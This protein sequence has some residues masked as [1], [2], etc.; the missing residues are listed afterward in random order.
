MKIVYLVI[1][2]L[3]ISTL[4]ASTQIQVSDIEYTLRNDD[5]S[6]KGF[7]SLGEVEYFIERGVEGTKISEVTD[8]GL[9]LLHHLKFRPTDSILNNVASS[10]ENSNSGIIYDDKYLYE[11]YFDYI[12]VIDILA[13]DLV[14]V[15]DLKEQNIVLVNDFVV[16]E[17]F[18]YFT[19]TS[20][21]NESKQIRYDRLQ[22]EFKE[23]TSDIRIGNDLYK[24]S[25]SK[26]QIVHFD[27]SSDISNTVDHG[28]S[29]LN[30]LRKLFIDGLPTLVARDLNSIVTIQDGIVKS[31]NFCSLPESQN[32]ISIFNNTIVTAELH[33]DKVD[34]IFT[35]PTN[36]TSSLQETFSDLSAAT[37]Q[38]FN[39]KEIS[40]G[41]IIFGQTNGW[42]GYGIFYIMNLETGAFT[43]LSL[44]VDILD[45]D[46]VIRYEN[47]LYIIV[48]DDIHYYGYRP[49][50]YSINL[51]D[52]TFSKIG[53]S[54]IID[55]YQI[56]IGESQSDREINVYYSTVDSASLFSLETE[57]SELEKIQ[58]LDYF[59]N[60]GIHFDIYANIWSQDDYFFSTS[61]A[62]FAM[63]DD[64]VTKVLDVGANTHSTSSF[65]EY[66]DK[67]FVLSAIG[68]N[69]YAL[70]IFP[71]FLTVSQKLI[72]ELNYIYYE[73]I[74]TENAIVNLSNGNL[75]GYYD[76]VSENYFAFADLGL[77]SA[78]SVSGNNILTQQSNSDG[79]AWKIHN[80]VTKQTITA[81]ITPATFPEPFP[82]G[83]G[84]F[85]L[86]GWQ[87]S[88]PVNL[89]YIDP[90]G[91]K[92]ILEE[93]FKHQLFRDGNKS[94]GTIKSLAF[95]GDSEM[96]IFSTDGNGHKIKTIPDS[97]IKYYQ[98]GEYYWYESDNR[99]FL[100]IKDGDFYDLY[101]F[102]YNSDPQL[103]LDNKKERL[104]LLME[105]EDKA[106]LAFRDSSQIITFYD[107]FYSNGTFIE[108]QSFQSSKY[109]SYDEDITKLEDSKYLLSLD[110]GIHGLEP[111]IYNSDNGELRLLK[112]IN[113]S[114]TSSQK[115][116]STISPSGEIYFTA[117]TPERDRQLFKLDNQ[118]VP[119]IEQQVPSPTDIVAYPSPSNGIIR[120]LED[121]QLLEIYNIKGQ[122][123]HREKDYKK[124]G[125]INLS[126]L[127]NGVYIIK[128]YPTTDRLK[129]GKLIIQK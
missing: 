89:F 78:K 115:G 40:D 28:F 20:T 36:C 10:Y 47:D 39:F 17:N 86:N 98:G 16:E 80:T 97:G 88:D 9:E 15:I 79:G 18:M 21:N 67:V 85:Y 2:F 58:E 8:N 83:Q 35:D 55:H 70:K 64:L 41:Y 30:S 87:F 102:D 22:E 104:I 14:K 32:I 96:I 59:R 7:I 126:H 68:E 125:T 77:G 123:I 23:V 50:F 112:D 113:N 110:D 93:N 117:K 114:F 81:D 1:V 19:A 73:R 63:Q 33:D 105:E 29:E 82:D 118:L 48:R 108:K 71:E 106:V 43:N 57:N 92:T 120:L 101:T 51:D 34:I 122:M 111:W 52:F 46:Q 121:Y 31:S 69:N 103:I 49:D 38:N 72:P 27:L 4:E 99:S 6:T 26:D 13:G 42:L 129:T 75:P 107:Y 124:Y 24:I 128:S 127:Q 53:N 5:Y 116:Y 91:Q 94:D 109:Y 76:V 60:H 11:L 3:L 90:N 37:F 56:I 95:D 119:V 45:K 100:E 66:N 65:L 62:I 54:E 25:N 61:E 74:N 84:G 44:P 12:Y